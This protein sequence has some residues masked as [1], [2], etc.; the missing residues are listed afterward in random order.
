MK[1]LKGP[2]LEVA[3]ILKDRLADFQQYIPLIIALR[4]PGLRDRHWDKLTDKIG[5]KVKPVV[6]SHDEPIGRRTRGYILT[7]D[8]SRAGQGGRVVL[9]DTRAAA[10]PE[11]PPRSHRGG[12]GVRQQGVRPREDARAHA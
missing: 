6:Y 1:Q 7:T 8:Q 3:T 12:V 10:E 2:P 9:S 11:R 4:N 5:I